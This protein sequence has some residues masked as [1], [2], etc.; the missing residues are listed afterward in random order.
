LIRKQKKLSLKI[1][2]LEALRRRLPANHP[3]RKRVEEEYKIA[4]A[5]YKGEKSI[6]YYLKDFSD[7]NYHIFH[8]LRL[9]HKED[10][11]FQLDI[12]ILT[13]YYLLILEVKNITGT[14]Y[15]DR[16]SQQLIR[17]SNGEQ[18]GFL[19]PIIQ[20]DRQEKLLQEWLVKNKLPTTPVNSHIVI[21]HPSTIMKTTP[22]HEEIF[23]KVIHA[24]SIPDKIYKLDEM[25]KRH[26]ISQKELD[27]ISHK[28]VEQNVSSNPD[29]LRKFQIDKSD[30]LTGVHCPGCSMLPIIKK[31][32][33]WHCPQCDMKHK[34][35]HLPSL[36]DY[37]LLLNPTITNKQAREYLHI[38]ST[39]IASKLLIS[40][41]LDQK[42]MKKNRSYE[43]SLFE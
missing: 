25:C 27:Q 17:I 20:V 36:N 24:A 35:A 4:M 11:Y 39:W 2:K 14:L 42:G 40:L 41:N 26:R 38:P 33:Y 1:L 18:E 12:V 16:H 29:F 19:D 7:N 37:F 30:I 3:S 9:H 13:S 28:L 32:G 10:D 31:R 23:Q 5:G 6:D 15:F 21:S 22:G 8:D 34:N 43:L